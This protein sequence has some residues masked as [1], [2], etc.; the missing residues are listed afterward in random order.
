MTR[1]R[2][3]LLALACALIATA[4]CGHAESDLAQSEPVW[5]EGTRIPILLVRD[6]EETVVDLAE[7]PVM[8]GAVRYQGPTMSAG[9]ENWKRSYSYRGVSIFE[10]LAAHGGLGDLET[11]T[12]VATD[13]WRKTL[14]RAALEGDTAAGPPVLALSRDEESPAAWENCPSLVF[15]SEDGS[16]GNDDMMETLGEEFAHYFGD[17]PATTGLLVKNV[18]ALIVDYSGGDLPLLRRL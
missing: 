2:L 17:Q 6:G 15:L 12:V 11:I 13:G 18:Y 4:G 7:F 3:V 5:E 8:E 9:T 1:G 10:I 16:F 14:P